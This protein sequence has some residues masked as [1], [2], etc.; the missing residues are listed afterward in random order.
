MVIAIN[1]PKFFTGG[2]DA[3]RSAAKVI[4]ED[5]MGRPE[6]RE[7]DNQMQLFIDDQSGPR[8]SS[9]QRE[10]LQA[11][12]TAFHK[13]ATQ[14]T[15][16][17][18]D[19]QITS[20]SLKKLITDGNRAQLEEVTQRFNLKFQAV[21]LALAVRM[22]HPELLEF[23]FEHLNAQTSVEQKQALTDKF[24]TSANDYLIRFDDT[25]SSINL[26][27]VTLDSLDLQALKFLSEKGVNFSGLLGSTKEQQISYRLML[28]LQ[29]LTQWLTVSKEDQQ[30]DER[31]DKFIEVV[32]FLMTQGF[33]VNADSPAGPLLVTLFDRHRESYDDKLLLRV[34][35][36][37]EMAGINFDYNLV[38][39]WI[40]TV[41][42]HQISS[43][44]AVPELGKF[45]KQKLAAL[46]VTV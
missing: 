7:F 35:Q 46:P 21:D 1:Y 16:G 36:K 13:T 39:D 45:V 19:Q 42:T 44:N 8:G 41:G 6:A 4:L 26:P 33:N 17:N 29:S 20:S 38:P 40:K 15:Y 18:A 11:F 30:I 10:K 23:L 25:L 22:G 32:K 24:S 12:H 28:G 43:Y 34:L 3:F 27:M 5:M 31:A 9:V 2:I 37:A 14:A